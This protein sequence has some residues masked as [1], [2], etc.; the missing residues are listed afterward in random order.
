[1]HAQTM[2]WIS[3]GALVLA[4][5]FWNSAANFQ[6]ELDLLVALAAGV[7][8]IQSFAAK[9]YR[10]AGG[11]LAIALLLNPAIP[12]FRLSGGVGL[13]LVMLSIATFAASLVALNPQTLLSIPSITG[14]NPG[15]PSL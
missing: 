8:L 5:V 2:K 12:V 15:S 13:S 3:I 7:V 1:M 9:K 11:F 10:W 6:M 4:V 14:R